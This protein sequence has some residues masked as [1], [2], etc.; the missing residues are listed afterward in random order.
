[1]CFP[2]LLAAVPTVMTGISAASTVVGLMGNSY[3]TSAAKNQ[4]TY[5]SQL[6]EINA[7]NA[8][9]SAR[10]ALERGELDAV[11]HGREVAALRGRQTASFA[12]AGL[13]AGYGT[14][15]DVANDTSLM[16]AEDTGRIY[17]NAS[18]EADSYRINASNYRA[19]AVGARAAGKNASTAGLINA[20]STLIG[21]ATQIAGVWGKYGK[22]SWVR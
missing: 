2:A 12:A 11:A 17:Q 15:L 22:P 13:E 5:Q 8:D 6:A 7:K 10:D 1:M 4:A 16:A 9:A 3:A 18:R 21:G 19:Q 14:P 20:G